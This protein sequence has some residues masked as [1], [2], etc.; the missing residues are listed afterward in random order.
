[1]KKNILTMLVLLVN[2][3][4][5]AVAQETPAITFEAG[6][7]ERTIT[8]G[9]NAAGT[10]KVDWGNGTLDEKEATAAYDGWD[11]ALDFTGTP[12]G[13]VK[14]Y[15]EGIN[16]FQAF[17]KYA[18]DATEITDGISSINFNDATGITELDIHQNNLTTVDLSKLT[19]LTKLNIGANDFETI[20]L[21]ANTELTNIDI[22]NS[23]NTG[24][25]T[26]IDL[27]KNTKLTSVVLSGNKLK[28]LDFTNNPLIKTF[29][30][31]NNEL[32]SVTFGENTVKNH[33]IQFGGNNLTGIN[34]SGFKTFSGTYLRLRDNN[35][36]KA[37]NIVL[38]GK[39]GQIW[40]DGNALPLNEL[41]ELKSKAKTVTYASTYT[42]A[43]AQQPYAIAES[44]NVGETVDLSSQA[45]LGETATVFTWKNAEGTALVEGT[46]Y[47][48][49]NGVFTFL[50]A[51]EAIHAEMTNAELDA[52]TAEKPYTT[53]TL[54]VATT[55]GITSMKATYGQSV[56]YNLN[57]QRIAAPAKGMFIQNGKKVIKK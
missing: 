57:G 31:L 55:T 25:L 20:N 17:T 12:S 2:V 9:L 48:A 23:K 4:L 53:T 51:Q 8:I 47:T 35:I 49:N 38:P 26:S 13:T 14:I 34:L 36:S 40:A 24:K 11:N 52:F 44:I 1:M 54:K 29:T 22:S 10:V 28:T 15:G 39:I 33:T 43:Q 37:A 30:V 18:E 5:T 3:V 50:T 46:D 41:Y 19:A 7:V 32:T 45:K 16:Y 42:K 27:S 6:A 21:S 56:Y